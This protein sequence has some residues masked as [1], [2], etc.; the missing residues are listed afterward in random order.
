MYKVIINTDKYKKRRCSK[1]NW[2]GG[3]MNDY[4]QAVNGWKTTEKNLKE[5]YWRLN[6]FQGINWLISEYDENNPDSYDGIE[7]FGMSEEYTK[8]L[9]KRCNEIIY[10]DKLCG[11]KRTQAPS[12]Y[13]CMQ[14]YFNI[15]GKIT[16]LKETGK[17]IIY[18]HELY[19]SRQYYKNMDGC[20][21]MIW[22]P[23]KVK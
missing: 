18:L 2:E 13:G 22:N 11:L 17:T 1:N 8:W 15:N 5:V 14:G 7:S 12:G 20:Y 10:Y 3:T 16:E 19:D 21:M 4:M 6:L 23:K 9:H